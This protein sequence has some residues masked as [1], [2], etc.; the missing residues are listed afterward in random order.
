M[1]L[2]KNNVEK[3]SLILVNAEYPIKDLSVPELLLPVNQ[4]R[5]IFLKAEAAKALHKTLAAIQGRKRIAMVSGYR[6]NEEQISIYDSSIK[7]NGED[8]TKKYVALPGCSE[9]QTGLAIDVGV[10]TKKIDFIRPSFPR[11]GI[12]QKFREIALDHGFIERYQ[13]DKEFITGI[14]EEQWHFRYAGIPHS[15]IMK[16]GNYSLE[17]Y[18]EYI[19]KYSSKSPL[20]IKH[21]GKNYEI[22]YLNCINEVDLETDDCYQY[23]VSGNNVDGCI[24]TRW[25]KHEKN[26][27]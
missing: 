27:K 9:H 1:I 26:T 5:T 20:R 22:F 25:R 23:D 15:Y 24:I 6:S 16:C 19:K 2:N 11:A 10:N 3:G 17:E 4:E 8:F 14:A 12:C 7:E 18:I 21:M 13:K